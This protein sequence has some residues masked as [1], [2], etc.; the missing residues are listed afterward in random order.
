[1]KAL[2]IDDIEDLRAL[3]VTILEEWGIHCTQAEDGKQALETLASKG[4]FDFCTVDIHMPVLDGF[5]FVSAVRKDR[6]Y[7]G[8]K[9]LVVTTEID[10]PSVDKALKLG[11]DE[12]LMKPFTRDMVDSKLRLMRLLP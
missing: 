2:V 1:M 8:T 4:P 5:S 3:L 10:K 7:V 6:A 9:L 12:Y 11:A